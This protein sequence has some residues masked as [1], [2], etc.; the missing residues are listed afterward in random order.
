MQRVT[1]PHPSAQRTL[2]PEPMTLQQLLADRADLW[3]GRVETSA[4]AEGLATGFADLDQ[5][6]PWHGWPTNGLVE[7]LTDQPGAGLALI[8]PALARLC[9]EGRRPPEGQA[10]DRSADPAGRPSRAQARSR[11]QGQGWLLLV[12]PPLIPYAPAL[13]A[14]GLDLER[15]ILVDAPAQGAWVME[16]GLRMG[17]CAAVLAWTA[18]EPGHCGRKQDAAWSTPVLRR[19]Q[20]AA[21]SYSTP[22][23]LLRPTSAAEQPSPAL[24]RLDCECGAERLQVLLRK[25][26]GSRAGMRLSL[27]APSLKDSM[28]FSA[29]PFAAVQRNAAS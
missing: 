25:L 12:N 8:L 15:L 21:Q 22:A 17:G 13:V 23:L 5:A 16:Q 28:P 29:A 11:Q 9:D 20:L 1:N 6:L 18:S 19:L 24:L 27:S 3:R 7:L 10:A 2:A 14:Q 26:R 4:V